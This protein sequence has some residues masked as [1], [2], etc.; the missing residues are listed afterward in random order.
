[1]NMKTVKW[2]PAAA[3]LAAD[4]ISKILIRDAVP[5]H[6]RLISGVL[7][8]TYR[9]NR[10]VAF[11]F[12]EDK[13]LLIALLTALL[14]GALAVWL[15]RDGSMNGLCACGVSLIVGGGVGNLIDRL[16]FGYVTDFVEVLFVRF[17]IFNVADCAICV[18]AALVIL[19][20]LGKDAPCRK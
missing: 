5:E 17:A 19:S 14:I 12:L 11:S 2:A 9:E 7:A 3:A 15:I 1:M 20:L 13:P 4:Q 10:G 8:L 6:A 18:G 16:L